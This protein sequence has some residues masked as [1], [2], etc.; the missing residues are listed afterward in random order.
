MKKILILTVITAVVTAILAAATK[1]GFDAHKQKI[2]QTNGML[3]TMG[4]DYQDRILYSKTL[5]GKDTKSVG[6]F[7]YVHVKDAKPAKSKK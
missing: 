1:P 2:K 4:L 6:C 3:A 7:G 5:R